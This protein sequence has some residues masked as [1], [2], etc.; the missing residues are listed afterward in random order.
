MMPSNSLRGSD[1]EVLVSQKC[2]HV[3]GKLGRPPISSFQ[4]NSD[5]IFI[6]CFIE[7]KAHNRETSPT[8]TQSPNGDRWEEEL[9]FD[10][11]TLLSERQP[12]VLIDR[13]EREDKSG[14]QRHKHLFQYLQ[15][16][17]TLM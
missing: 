6:M 11:K 5:I 12:P 2:K 13:G 15:K 3:H 8:I 16:I 1:T 4:F 7:Q 17:L 10:R 9:P 14:A